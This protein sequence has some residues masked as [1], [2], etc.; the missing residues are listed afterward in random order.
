M[1][2]VA[3]VVGKITEYTVAP[4]VR[5][6]SYLICYEGN[7][8]TLADDVK[9]L[10]AARERMMVLVE[11]ERRN[12]KTNFQGVDNW[13]E[14]VNEVI[15]KAT[16]LQND[17]R[18]ANVSCSAWPFHN[19]ISRHQLSRKATKIAKDAVQV[20]GKG[21]F[22][23]LGFRSIL[24]GVASSSG[25][26]GDE[27]YETRESLKQEIMNALVDLNSG[28]IG[29]YGLGGVGKTTLLVG[30]SQMAKEKKLFNEVVTTHVS[31]NPDLKTI[32][33]EIADLLGLRFDEETILGRAH[34]LRQ[35]IKMEKSILVIL[36]D[37]WTRIDLKEVGIPFGNEHNG[38]KLLMTSRDQDVLVQMDVSKD[39]TF[40][41]NIMSEKE[42]WRLFQLTAGD[43]V[44]N[45]DLKDVAIKVAQKCEGLPLRVV[46]VASAMKNKRDVESWRDALSKLQSSNHAGVNAA[47]YS[48][49]ELSY[50]SLESNEVKALFL[51]YA[52]IP[53]N[54]AEYYLKVAM[55]LDILKHVNTMDDARNRHYT[56]IKSLETSCL[57]LESKT[58][59]KV[60]MHDFVR[61]F[62]IS[63]ARRD[64]HVFL[65]KFADNEWPTNDLLNRCTQ[66]ILYR[67]Q[68]MHKL[69]K[70]I[71]C[72]SIKF[73]ILYSKNRSL[74]IPDMFFKGMKSLTVLDLTA[75]NLPSL[76][77]SFRF[78]TD[79]KSLCLD[80]CVL[81]NMDSIKALQNLEI[82]SLWNSS[83][84]KLP[85]EI[86]RL[87]QLRMLDLSNSGIEV[88][89]PN[90]ISSLTKLE[91]LYMG[92]TSINW[93][94][95][96]STVQHE[97]ASIA[98]LR[99]LPNLTA[100]ELQIRETWMLPRDLQVMF[101][102]LKRYKIAI[103]DVWEWSDIKDVTL[104][105]LMLKLGTNIH[106]EHGIKALIKSV[107]NLY[108]D[109]IYGI[110]NVVYQLDGEGF[111]FLKHLHVQNNAN[112]KH[113]VDSKER[114]QIHVSFPILETLVLDNLHNLD[115]IC[116]GPLSLASFRCLSVIKVKTCFQ[117]KYLF[118]FT[119][120]KGLSHLS[121]IEVC[122]CNSMKEIVLEDNNPSAN[123][124]MANEKIEFN[125]LR[126]LT[127]EHLETLDNFFSN[128]LT[129]SKSKQNHQGSE[130][131]VS[132][133]FFNAQ[134]VFSNLDTLK[135]S[136]LNLSK[137]WDDNHSSMYNLT[138]LIVENCG[139]LK[140]LFSST[141]VESFKILTHLEI[142]KCPL[143]EEIISKQERN[144]A[145][146]EVPFFKLEKLILKD[147]DKLKTI[148]HSQFKSLKSLK[149]NNCE[150][151]VVVFPSSMQKTYNKLEMLEVKNC[152]LVEVIFELTFSCTEE[153]T[154]DL[155]Q[156]TINELPK[157]KKIWSEDPQGILNFQSLK[158]VRLHQC[159]SLEYLLR[160]SVATHCS[161]LKE[162]VIVNCASIKEIVAEEKESRVCAA[163]IFE[164]NQLNSLILR[165]SHRLKGFYVG[166]H[167]LSCPSLRKINVFNC[168]KLNLY[169]TLSTINSISSFQYDKLFDI[170]QQPPFLAEEVIPNLEELRIEQKDAGMI[171]QAQNS[172]ALFTKLTKLCLS[173]YN[174]EEA[175]FP[176]WF[177]NNVHTIDSLWVEWS[178]FRKIFQDEGQITETTHTRVKN[179][180]LN[181]LHKLQHICEEGSR[182]NPILEFLECLHVLSCS[183]MI[184]LFPSSVTL[185][186]L[187]HIE[188]TCCNGLKNLITIA[189]A[190][191]L[192]K[193]TSLEVKDC[194]SLEEII[195][196]VE[197]VDIAFISL[198]VLTLECLPSLKRFC[199]SKCFLKFPLLKKVVVR[200]CPYMT[201]FSEGNTST[202]NLRKVKIAE[203]KKESFWKRNLNDTIQKMFEDKVAFS[204]FKYLSLS[205]HPVLKD[206]WYGQVDHQNVFC[207]LKHLVVQRCDFLSHVLFP[208][209]I[210]Q[211]LHGL[212]KLEV[213]ECDSL[214]AIFDVKGMKSNELILC[215]QN[216]QLKTLT[217]SCLPNLEHIWNED[218]HET[219]NFGNLCSMDVSS[220]Q[221]LSY[222]FSL[223]LC[224]DLGNLEMLKIDSCGVKDI[225]AMKEGSMEISFNFPQLN[226][227]ALH[228]LPN[229]KSF[230]QGKHTLE[231]SSLKTWKTWNSF[232]C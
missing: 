149:V 49:L 119:M 14:N 200:E 230:Y 26:R 138:S 195:T 123:N 126:S 81:E 18:R 140:Y 27:K 190:Q 135:L 34:R 64:K 148:W 24:D 76:P 35:R 189:T 114:N 155:E 118:S 151:I 19:L 174:N 146:N 201:K 154:T 110:Q 104:R 142:S 136:S 162:L 21:V 63:I 222:I 93:E 173:M 144:N 147:M 223:S 96:N 2:I 199:S 128:S 78:L 8:K 31:I 37:I 178:C 43:V 141:V 102:K 111:P 216:S 28:N 215:K 192:V 77:T 153:D 188:I 145:L 60:E 204:K 3:A 134:A 198:Q 108:L 46:T 105:T 86:G 23:R 161:H 133:P 92:S 229:L 17:P 168:S 150:K 132:T 71:D 112:M 53:D 15:E 137:I 193:L 11:E 131:Y 203:N 206:L 6:A 22:D 130:P 116:H 97:N 227:L 170:S 191:S 66:I 44:N 226:T 54:G 20:Q 184:N 47:T 32:Q 181:T 83:M 36:D 62:A 41:L 69:P 143:M 156:V 121:K 57:L 125:E 224:Q 120:V 164:F 4:I 10:D 30:I 158:Y 176:Y 45:K 80:F 207:N 56:I 68:H 172:C 166:K 65:S 218:P 42:T 79:L 91:E 48:A 84:I 13:I 75:L 212:E 99:K 117:L 89:P 103:G 51:L 196:G 38:C 210:V 70:M 180:R 219:I 39:F 61:D 101:E 95:V 182:V 52:L 213:K 50:N 177:L 12:G 169:R 88:V 107:E 72:P 214:K 40:R 160:L 185:K 167:T 124:N 67:C 115:H 5:Q 106:L 208:S 98:E 55:G 59:E 179:L 202:P 100:L 1:E 33:G 122:H 9:D 29:V 183:S 157:L 90:I 139:G 73:F 175:T 109:D 129:H 220:C 25:T 87:T 7:F 228:C 186:H 225:V 163:P 197:N 74:E 205:D 165:N 231:C 58:S 221:S 211:V 194:K 16:Q 82:L 113:I 209:N 127:L 187:D 217:L 85:R 159:G 152:A 94:V 171:L 232:L